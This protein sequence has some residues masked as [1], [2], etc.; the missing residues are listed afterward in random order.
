V[1]VTF[2]KTAGPIQMMLEAGRAD[3]KGSFTI[4]VAGRC[5]KPDEL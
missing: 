4:R 5:L 2:E 3:L 1:E